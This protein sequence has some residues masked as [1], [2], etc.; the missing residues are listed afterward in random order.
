MR[1]APMAAR[2]LR[3]LI[4]DTTLASCSASPEPPPPAC[5]ASAARSAELLSPTFQQRSTVPT[6]PL[7]PAPSPD[8]AAL[9]YL[10]GH[11]VGPHGLHPGVRRHVG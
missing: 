6:D 5:A 7:S 4:G 9:S 3:H 10:V 2:S 1:C 11:P 8:C